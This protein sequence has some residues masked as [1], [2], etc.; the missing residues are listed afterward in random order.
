MSSVSR[1]VS[2]EEAGGRVGGRKGRREEGGGR[3]AGGRRERGRREEAGKARKRIRK[4][5]KEEEGKKREGKSLASSNKTQ[6]RDPFLSFPSFL[7]LPYLPPC[8]SILRGRGI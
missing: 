3:K 7:P 8:C 2:L 6:S 4:G 5:E 1:S